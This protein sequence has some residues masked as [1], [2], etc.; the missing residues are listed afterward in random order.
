[1]KKILCLMLVLVLSF[2][3]VSCKKDKGDDN[4]DNNAN[5]NNT[6]TVSFETFA[7]AIA[8]NNASAVVVDITT[9]TALG[10]L[11]AKYEIYFAADGSATVKYEY[12]RFLEFGEGS[13]DDIKTTVDGT[14]YRDK[15]GKYSDTAGIDVSAV[16]ASTALN[17]T[18]LKANASINTSGDELNVVVAKANTADVFGTA[19]SSDVA[20]KIVLDGE[21]LA[22]IELTSSDRDIVYTYGN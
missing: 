15:D 19:F 11:T 18:S 5:T 17:I 20:L 3:I 14:V 2:G 22:K 6:A 8:N 10:D 12:E 16:S 7:A 1:M 4:T 13:A 21:K 9:A